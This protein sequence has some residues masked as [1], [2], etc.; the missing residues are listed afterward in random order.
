MKSLVNL[1][2]ASVWFASVVSSASAKELPRYGEFVFSDECVQDNQSGDV[3]GDRFTLRRLRSG[4]IVIYQYGAGPF[5]GPITAE[6][7]T[8]NKK[9]SSIRIVVKDEWGVG[10]TE[11]QAGVDTIEGTISADKLV[12]TRRNGDTNVRIL[13]RVPP[14]P[15]PTCK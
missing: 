5:E 4:D 12:V 11:N 10:A 15:V 9:N 13:P 7:V 8:I 6:M 2:G 1:I 3:Q 14:G